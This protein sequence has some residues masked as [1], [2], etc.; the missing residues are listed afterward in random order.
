MLWLYIH[1]VGFVDPPSLEQ[2][3]RYCTGNLTLTVCQIPLPVFRAPK[4]PG[5]LLLPLEYKC[6]GPLATML[7][8]NLEN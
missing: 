8:R 1:T 4:H 5:F 3:D 7:E 6:D 2:Q